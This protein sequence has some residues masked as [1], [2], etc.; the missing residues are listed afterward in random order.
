VRHRNLFIAALARKIQGRRQPDA[1]FLL[2]RFLKKAGGEAQ[3]EKGIVIP[4]DMTDY[5]GI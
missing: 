2:R 5:E 1:G 3:Y 4:E